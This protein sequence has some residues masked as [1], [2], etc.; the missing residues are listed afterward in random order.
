MLETLISVAL[1]GIVTGASASSLPPML[2]AFSRQNAIAQV[3]GDLRL[4]RERAVTSN[5]KA[6]VVFSAD[7][8]TLQRE[9]PAGSAVY[10]DDGAPQPLPVGITVSANPVDPT[11]DSRGLTTQNYAIT[12]TD[13]YDR[14]QTIT[15]TGIGRVIIG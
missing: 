4:A 6:R 3:A 15:V 11:F 12:L 8:Y 10:I 2:A 9:N 13:R 5:G 7:S 14:S 1:A